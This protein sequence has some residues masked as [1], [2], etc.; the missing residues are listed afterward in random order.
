MSTAPLATTLTEPR[1]PPRMRGLRS[2][3]VAGLYISPGHNYFGHHGRPPGTNPSRNVSRVRCVAGRGLVGDRFFDHKPNYRG[4][5]TFFSFEVYHEL[6]ERL[7]VTDRD[8]SV[9]RRNVLT[10]GEDLNRYIGRE[11]ELQGV[12]FEG[13]AECSPCYWMDRAFG[14]GAHEA[15]NGRGGLRARILTDGILEVESPAE[16][17]PQVGETRTC[18]P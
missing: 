15:L 1:M 13:V 2:R 7:G 18:P 5:I 3:R 9:F 17:D 6:C 12:R 4:Q 16:C 8:P 11:F 10:E 14:E